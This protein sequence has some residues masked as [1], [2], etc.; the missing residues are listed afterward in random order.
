MPSLTFKSVQIA[1]VDTQGKTRYFYLLGHRSG[2]LGEIVDDNALSTAYFQVE[3]LVGPLDVAPAANAPIDAAI[4][5]A[6]ASPIALPGALLHDKED[7]VLSENELKQQLQAAG[8]DAAKRF[9]ALLDEAIRRMRRVATTQMAAGDAQSMF[10]SHPAFRGKVFGSI[11][12]RLS[13]WTIVSETIVKVG[14]HV[15]F[16]A[17]AHAELPGVQVQ[18]FALVVVVDAGAGARVRIDA[19][20]VNLR[21]PAFTLPHF[22]A[23]ALPP[24]DLADA[25]DKVGTTLGDVA[26]ATG[27]TA[28]VTCRDAAGQTTAP[29]LLMRVNGDSIEWAVVASGT[30]PAP[31]WSDVANHLARWDITLDVNTVA[32]AVVVSDL[33]LAALGSGATITAKVTV[34]PARIDVPPATRRFGPFDIGWKHMTASPSVTVQTGAGAGMRVQ[35]RFD[36]LYLRLHDDPGVVLT[37]SGAVDIDPSGVRILG[38]QLVAPFPLTLVAYAADGILRAADGV[39][40]VALDLAAA[41]AEQLRILLDILGA[42]AAA[43]GR[44]ALFIADSAAVPLSGLSDLVAGGLQAVAGLVG[45]MFGM[46]GIFAKDARRLMAIELRIGTDPLELRQVLVTLR[47]GPGQPAIPPKLEMPGLQLDAREAWQPGLLFDFATL[48]GA[49]LVLL[50]H[51]APATDGTIATISTDLWL[52]RPDPD[53]DQV[54]ALRDADKTSGNRADK[55]L[56]AITIKHRAPQDAGT[57][58]VVLAGLH[59]ARPLFLQ[60]LKGKLDTLTLPGVGAALRTTSGEF[61][62]APLGEEI[63]TYVEFEPDRILPLLGMGEPGST[64]GGF[65]DQLRDSLSNV[66]W[67]RNQPAG[68]VDVDKNVAQVDLQLGLKAAGIETSLTLHAELALDTL[69]VTFKSGD[70]FPLRSKRIEANALGLDWIVEQRDEN[71]RLEDET[72][73]MFQIGFG[74]AQSGLE[75]AGGARMELRFAD[76][77][78]D[79]KGVVFEVTTFKIGPGGLDLVAR[80]VDAPVRMQGLNV[81]FRFTSGELEIKSGRLVRSTIMGRGSL[82]PDLI[83]AA[84]C[85]VALTFGEVPGEGIVLQS[86]K[87]ELD[88]KNDPVV[89]H[90]SRFTLTITDLDLSFVRDNGYHFYYLVTGS[91][92]FTPKRGEFENGLLQYLDGVQM[93]LERTPLAADPRVLLKHVSFQKALNPK[94]TFNLFNLFTFELRGFGYHPAAPKFGGTPAVNI[95]GQIKFVEMGDV[96]QPSIGFHGLWIAPPAK[97]ESLPR[98]KADG[99]GI[100]LNLKGA[101]RV[102]GSV[103]AVDADTRTVEGSEFAPPGYNAYGFLGQGEFDIPGWGTMG[104]SLGFLELERPDHPGERRKSFYFYAEQKQLAIEI[105][106]PLWVFYMREAGFGMG[107]RYTLDALQAADKASSVPALVSAL[108]DVSKRQGELHKFSTWKPEFEGD[109]VTLALKGAIQAYPASKTWNPEEEERAENPFMFDLVAAIRSDF[110]LFMGL[111]GWLGTNYIDYLNDK[112]GLRAKPGLRGYLYISAPQQRLLARMVGDSKGYIGDRLPAL[113]RGPDGTDPPMRRALQ[114]IDWS[115]TLFIKPG[116]FHYELGW[117]NQLVARL[118][119]EPNMRVTVRGGMIFRATDDGLLWGYNIEADAFFRFSGSLQAGPLGVCAEATLTASLVARVLCYLSWRMQGSLIYGLVALDAALTVAVRAWLKVDLRFT[120][121]TIRIGFS[122]AL[123]LSAAVEIAIS[124]GGIGARVH[125]R[126]AISAF[127]CTLAVSVGFTLGGGQLEEA[128]ARV[129]RFLAMSIGSETPDTAPAMATAGADRRLERDA[130]HAE[131]PAQAPA[132]SEVRTPTDKAPGMVDLF[133]A[134]YGRPIRPTDFWIVLHKARVAPPRR[135]GTALPFRDDAYGFA[136]LVPRQPEFRLLNKPDDYAGAFYAAP[137]HLKPA[138]SERTD[139]DPAHRFVVPDDLSAADTQALV[140]ALARGVWRYDATAGFVP[141]DF[142]NAQGVVDA[143]VRWNGFLDTEDG[144]KTITLAQMFDEC[145]LSDA[146]WIDAQVRQPTAWAEPLPR[147]H[148]PVRLADHLTEEERVSE[149]DLHQRAHVATE[150]ANPIVEAVHQARSTILQMFL[151][152]FLNFCAQP[153][154][155]LDD[156]DRRSHVCD[157][158]LLFYGELATLELLEKLELVKNELPAHT[159]GV[160][161]GPGS[162]RVLNPVATWF[163]RQDPELA[164]DTYTV[165]PDGVKLDWQLRTRHAESFSP[166]SGISADDELHHYRIER[167][168]EG[169]EFTPRT[170]QV[171]AAATIGGH[172]EGKPT[173]PLVAP[174]FQYADDLSDLPPDLRRTLLPSADEAAALQAAAS[175]VQR[176]GTRESISIGYTVTPVDIAGTFGLS[177]SFLVDVRRPEAPVRPAEAELRFVVRRLGGDLGEPVTGDQPPAGSLAALIA[178]KDASFPA[179]ANDKNRYYE[180]IAVPEHISPSGHYGT[181]GL[182]ERRLGIGSATATSADARTWP[183]TRQGFRKLTD[184]AGKL[185]DDTFMDALEPDRDTLRT[186]PC[187]K[188]LEGD[189]GLDR[190]DTSLSVADGLAGFLASLWVHRAT[191]KRIATRFMLVTVQQHEAKGPDGKSIMLPFRSKPVPVALEV[192][193][194]PIQPGNDI[195]L[196]R[197]EAFEWPVHLDM[198]PL[199]PGQVHARSGFARLR[200]PAWDGSLATLLD[201]PQTACLL[202]RDPERRILTEIAF[203]A[204]AR[205]DA[206]AGMALAPCHASTVAGFDIHELDLDDLAPLDTQAVPAFA[207]NATTW[208]RAR[209]VARIERVSPARARLSPDNNR[210]WLGWHAHYPSEAWRVE[211]RGKGRRNQSSPQRAEWYGAAESTLR[212]AARMPRMRLFPTAPEAALGSLMEKGRPRMLTALLSID[213]ALPAEQRRA[214]ESQLARMRLAFLAPDALPL[215]DRRPDLALAPTAGAG[216]DTA[217]LEITLP[218]GRFTAPLLRAALLRLAVTCAPDDMASAPALYD[219]LQLQLT[220]RHGQYE[221]GAIVLPLKLSGVLHPLLEEV[222]GELEYHATGEALYRRYTV[223]VQPVQPVKVKD[224]AGFLQATSADTDPYGWGALQQLGLAC[225]VKLYDRDHDEHVAPAALNRRIEAVMSAA[226]ARYGSAYPGG[227]GQPMVEVLLRPGADRVSGPFNAVLGSSGVEPES[228]A[229]SLDDKGLSIVQLSLRPSPAAGLQY[230]RLALPWPVADTTTVPDGGYHI[231]FPSLD[232]PYD[233]VRIVDGMRVAVAPDVHAD[234]PVTI[235]M[236]PWSKAAPAAQLEFF[237]RCTGEPP[238]SFPVHLRAG[239]MPADP[240][241]PATVPTPVRLPDGDPNGPFGRFPAL[242]NDDWAA[243]LVPGSASPDAAAGFASLQA[244]LR[245]ALPD[246]AWPGSSAAPSVPDLQLVASAY[247]NWSQRFLDH[248][249][250]PGKPRDGSLPFALAAPIKCN[251]W[252]LASDSHGMLTMSFLHADRWA[253]A[254]AYAVRPTPRYQNLALGA[255]YYDDQAQTEALITPRMLAAKPAQNDGQFVQPIGYALAVSPRTERIEPPVFLGSTLLRADNGAESAWELVV[256]R[257]GEEALAFSNRAL[258]ARLGTEGT[259]LSFV[260]AYRDPKWPGRLADVLPVP[261]LPVV[262][263]PRAA[264]LPRQP[265]AHPPRIDGADIGRL[266]RAYPSLW[267]GA[268][269]WRIGELPPHYKLTA[270]AVAR[271]GLVVSR[272]VAA[273]LNDT[274][275]RPLALPTEGGRNVLGTPAFGIERRDGALMLVIRAL[276]LVS[277]RD[278]TEPGALKWI[279]ADH[280]DVGWWPDPAVTYTLLRRSTSPDGTIVEDEDASVRLVAGTVEDAAEPGADDRPI[281][282]RRRGVRFGSPAPEADR[283]EVTPWSRMD[284]TLEFLLSFSMAIRWDGDVSATLTETGTADQRAAFNAAAAGFARIDAL[285]RVTISQFEAAPADAAG[286]AAWFARQVTAIRDHAGALAAMPDLAGPVLVAALGRAADAM[287]LEAGQRLPDTWPEAVAWLT[288]ERTADYVADEGS[289]PR[290]IELDTV[291]HPLVLTIGEQGE[292][293]VLTGLPTDDEAA[294]VQ[295]VHP[296]ASPGGRLW[297][298]CRA[299]LLGDAGAVVVRALDTHNAIARST[300]AGPR[301]DTPGQLDIVV[302]PPQWLA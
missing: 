220:G 3:R 282:I 82:P 45:K 253:H 227:I 110:T 75:L 19:H 218:E 63:E 281:L 77:S 238:A 142:G 146:K 9:L 71:A 192:R 17:H 233:V 12:L 121:F 237:I 211:K 70:T 116:L 131:A 223:T 178:V 295:N 105:P 226:V 150:A 283:P 236:L 177:R 125:A 225:T 195:G 84:D 164:A 230:L 216:T 108:D 157:M 217:S 241:F 168:I 214:L 169:Q 184:D 143:M 278:L 18:G 145:F 292:R 103:L 126:V 291:P 43:A 167:V 254:R 296:A 222:A 1:A 266:A 115:A 257:H 159:G 7:R 74:G 158:G 67:I 203:E 55:P 202:V 186:F 193:I 4:D 156:A 163:E 98:I 32:D 265:D 288:R 210:D 37:V 183:I 99:L 152:Q 117:P 16:T 272:V 33:S 151:D 59:R 206:A 301:W 267:K 147:L 299:L 187:W 106:T 40:R 286:V 26:E 120:S 297:T 68:R 235:A 179:D 28:T 196:M 264:A 135:D 50:Q 2:T 114:S 129:Q 20:G 78:T 182:T 124:T 36:E 219:H 239:T 170:A 54:S 251:P 197:P 109:R 53:G 44:A 11:T 149:R 276:R 42:M 101:I 242:G 94:K 277:Y 207:L 215:G 263:P 51:K 92:R 104:A 279:G 123:Q 268:D 171:K 246:V 258:F 209:R 22:D 8:K 72:I 188:R 27:V 293:L 212:F 144:N 48:P 205:F 290:T 289:A 52:R 189:T 85:S 127:G 228:D 62:L 256:A 249:H 244:N 60:R 250:A 175:W 13:L 136:L 247:V 119:D 34:Q 96:M 30:D 130:V 140:A 64:G 137:C 83:G 46:L 100:D 89:C 65:L 194:E 300:T 128:R 269:V 221:T 181:D 5:L 161:N 23:A 240:D 66:V 259:A 10:L 176:F 154:R 280:A 232:K 86:G 132:P 270:L 57:A 287:A 21:L 234:A 173:V 6:F 285:H 273:S 274:P 199:D 271:A 245:F 73:D 275:R 180:L 38:L 81:P 41:T 294:R 107:F 200:A 172:D 165:S 111:R 79:G 95:S 87:V 260:R 160:A 39:L 47:P 284:K 148:L 139:T 231:V 162:L 61:V 252:Q 248:G 198:P 56:L 208:R 166:A 29:R 298:M 118:F 302:T 49:Y 141:F 14:T 24:L 262:Y 97:G 224:L 261:M 90:A 91:L 25:L 213:A 31:D 122:V 112:D 93:D 204:A 88:K 255:G 58:M 190:V 153:V 76:L 113:K 133:R 185:P 138:S 155:P 80:V 134:S 174:E 191:G 229:F 243:L 35:L 69:E 15:E 102:R 201:A